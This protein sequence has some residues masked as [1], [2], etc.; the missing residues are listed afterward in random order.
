MFM[1]TSFNQLQGHA[2]V[3]SATDWPAGAESGVGGMLE[4]PASVKDTGPFM[5][6]GT[7]AHCARHKKST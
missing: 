7:G 5:P 2:W 6:N 4:I 3:I 1:G